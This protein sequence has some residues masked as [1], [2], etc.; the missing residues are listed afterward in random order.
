MNRFCLPAV[1]SFLIIGATLF[2]AQAEYVP[3]VYQ[4]AS[5]GDLNYRIHLPDPLEAGKK[6]PLVLMFHGAGERG[7]D[8]TRQLKNAAGDILKYVQQHKQAIILVPQCPAGQQWV[9]VPWSADAH[10]MPETPSISMR[11]AMGLLNKTIQEQPVDS[12]RVYVVG[13][14][15]GGFGTW[16][17]IQR[18]PHLFAAAIPVCGGGD[19]AYALKIKDVPIW[20]FH[21]DSDPVVK[22][23]RSRDM[24][25]ALRKAGGTPRYTE[26]PDT[27]HNAWTRT[28]A[29]PDVLKWLFDQ[30]KECP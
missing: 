7:N 1:T 3:R 26:Y 15:M 25:E 22:T 12:S 16:D 28:F 11:L 21:G 8:N 6:Y 20:A 5:G 14:S 18:N 2:K 13:L 30:K 10:T 4:G 27:K 29:N 9:D 17:I 23:I 19:P 24:V